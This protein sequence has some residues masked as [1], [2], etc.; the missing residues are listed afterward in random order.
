MICI[1]WYSETKKTLYY[2][3]TECFCRK[4]TLAPMFRPDIEPVYV[5][6]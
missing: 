2:L 5:G 4:K 6:Y 3:N 1:E